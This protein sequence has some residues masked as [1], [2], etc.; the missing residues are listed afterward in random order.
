MYLSGISKVLS[1]RNNVSVIIKYKIFII[2]YKFGHRLDVKLFIQKIHGIL[3][4]TQ[5]HLSFTQI[6]PTRFHF[7]GI[8]ELIM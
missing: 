4:P 6:N 8:I 3:G 5:T 1:I 2:N 7:I